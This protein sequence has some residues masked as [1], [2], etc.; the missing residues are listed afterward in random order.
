MKERVA[1]LEEDNS[2]KYDTILSLE[3]NLG[4]ARAETKEI[5]AEMDV[6]NQVNCFM[7]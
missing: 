6:I 1:Q 2:K 5:Q 4:I 7:F 3:S